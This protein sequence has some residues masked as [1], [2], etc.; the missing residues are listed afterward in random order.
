VTLLGA[1]RSA[2]GGAALALVAVLLAAPG[3]QPED[4][5][6]V[7]AIGSS[8]SLIKDGSDDTAS[9]SVVAITTSA[10]GLCTGSLI[11]PNVVLTARHCVS[12]TLPNGSA[13]ICDETTS[14]PAFS[15]SSFFVTTADV[16]TPGTLLEFFVDEVVL[17][18]IEGDQL[19]GNDMAILI[20]AV[21]VDASQTLP[22]EPRLSDDPL[23]A[24]ET[25]AAVGYGAVD[26]AGNDAGTRR[27]REGLTVDCV[28]DGCGDTMFGTNISLIEWAG[29]GGVCQGDS[30]G[31]ALDDSGR[32]I[33][34]TSRGTPDCE[35]SI[36]AYTSAWEDWLKDTV[37]YAS[38]IGVYEAPSWTSG[39]SVDPE[40]SMPVGDT[41][42]SDAD[43]PSG[44]CLQ[45]G[46]KRYC[47]RACASEHACPTQYVCEDTDGFGLA[48]VE[49][50]ASEP[51]P[52]QSFERADRGGCSVGGVAGRTS[53]AGWLLLGLTGL[54]LGRRRRA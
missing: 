3:C 20:L 6:A 15:S 18:P 37:V 29:S 50:K 21:N 54:A 40:H 35:A 9:K 23:M 12:P 22:Y 4:G 36:Y 45:D 39:S 19:C 31:P 27:R 11:A 17:L 25:F 14:G 24:G 47:T 7:A 16:V 33:G 49:A 43:C 28:T 44:K 13:V 53:Q 42:S 2:R 10:G 1:V 34:V 30:G 38:G 51:P 26:G 48:C 41:C 46:D 8:E 5:D 32:V 52:T